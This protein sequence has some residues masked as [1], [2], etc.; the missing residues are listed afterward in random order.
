[1]IGKRRGRRGRGKGRRIV[2]GF[3]DGV[4]TICVCVCVGVWVFECLR[5]FVHPVGLA[6]SNVTITHTS[7]L[8]YTVY[9]YNLTQSSC[10]FISM[11]SIVR[12]SRS[13]ISGVGAL[14]TY[15]RLLPSSAVSAAMRLNLVNLS[16]SRPKI[17]V[18][19]W[20]KGA[21]VC[22]CLLQ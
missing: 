21:Y 10:T 14:C 18:L 8:I 9:L 16:E 12:A 3:D 6:T 15:T 4:V 5:K 1:M 19:V 17:L 13:V 22:V 2:I 11:D 7:R 20:L